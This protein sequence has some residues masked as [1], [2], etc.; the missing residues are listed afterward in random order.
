MRNLYFNRALAGGL[1]GENHRTEHDERAQPTS[2]PSSFPRNPQLSATESPNSDPWQYGIKE[3]FARLNLLTLTRVA[4][5]LTA[6]L[7][8]MLDGEETDPFRFLTLV[9]LSFYTVFA[10]A[11]HFLAYHR[12]SP[13]GADQFL[14]HCFELGL[15]TL[16]SALTPAIDHS[17]FSAGLLFSIFSVSLQHGSAMGRRFLIASL[18]L[19]LLLLFLSAADVMRFGLKP[20]LPRYLVNC[21]FIFVAGYAV[22]YWGGTLRDSGRRAILLKN[23]ARLSNPR[24]G[25]ERTLGLIIDQ[26]R[27][28][29]GARRCLL[30]MQER[31]NEVY[32]LQQA[33][34]GNPTLS[35][36]QQTVPAEVGRQ[37]LALPPAQAFVHKRRLFAKHSVVLAFDTVRARQIE[38]SGEEEQRLADLLQSASLLSLPLNFSHGTTGRLYICSPKNYLFSKKDITFMMSAASHFIPVVENVRLVDRL[39]SDAANHERSRLARDIHDSTVQPIIGLKLGLMGVRQ[40]L[41]GGQSNVAGDIERLLQLT[42]NE[43]TDLRRYVRNLKESESVNWGL[44][45]AVESFAQRFK[46]ETGI[47]VRVT[48]DDE[49]TISDRLAAEAFQLVAEA[50]SNIRRH[51]PSTEAHINMACRYQHF[52]LQVQNK[53]APGATAADFKPRSISERTESLGGICRVVQG[54][55]GFTNLHISI[56]L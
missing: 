7:V 26:L 17:V 11:Y 54:A 49:L 30:V 2:S 13:L 4:I 9:S 27:Q 20:Q 55:D 39:A 5:A 35:L 44:A 41:N 19:L 52:I 53:R 8:I 47:E 1:L 51:T 37:L 50:L 32:I 34:R 12:T 46:D 40:K 56:P 10:I 14:L 25:V 33:E 42:E 3:E 31:G 22:A 23:I 6:L 15:F 29:Y 24:F 18:S 38:S 36:R 48:A 43:L 28:F 21:F 45:S 16:L